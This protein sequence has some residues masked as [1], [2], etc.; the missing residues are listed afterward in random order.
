MKL[1]KLVPGLGLVCLAVLLLNTA[2][3]P[4]RSVSDIHAS[5][6]WQ[7]GVFFEQN[8]GQERN[9][10]SFVAHS[11]EYDLLLG[12]SRILFKA[13]GKEED[14]PVGLEHLAND[15]DIR[16]ETR[17]PTVVNYYVGPDP[18]NWHSGIPTFGRV[19]YQNVFSGIDL[20]FYEKDGNTEF[21]FQLAPGADPEQIRL[22]LSK[23]YAI[24]GEDLLLG[25]GSWMR[26]R[27][28]RAYQMIGGREREVAADYVIENDELRIRTGEYD[29]SRSLV[30]DPV[31]LYQGIVPNPETLSLGNGSVAS[32]SQGSAY[33][34]GIAS[35]GVRGPFYCVVTKFSSSGT[36]VY[37]T[38][39]G[40]VGL[41][42]CNAIAADGQGNAYITGPGSGF[43]ITQGV[44]EPTSGS[45]FVA[46][47]TST[48][49]LSYS[50]YVGGSDSDIAKGI[51]VDPN[52][53][54]YVTGS[55]VSNDLPLANAFQS[56]LDGS[57]DAFVSVLNPTASAFVYST[58]LG[59]GSTDQG[60]GIAVD[61]TG[62]AYVTGLTGSTDFPLKNPLLSSCVSPCDSPFLT[63]FDST[64]SALVYSTYV[65]LVGY[66]SN[67][68][69]IALDQAGN[70][71][72]G[73]GAYIASVSPSGT[74][75]FLEGL[76]VTAEPGACGVGV[77][78]AGNAY[79]G[80][81]GGL[82]ASHNPMQQSG[83]SF[84]GS[85]TNSGTLIYSTPIDGVVTGV[86]G[87]ES[88]NVYLTGTI[89]GESYVSVNMTQSPT[90]SVA[91][92]S[93]ISGQGGPALAYIPPSLAFGYQQIGVTSQP[94]ALT[95]EDLASSGTLDLSSIVVSG[96]GFA[97]GTSTCGPTLTAAGSTGAT[98]TY[99]VTFTPQ[100]A[101][102][103]TG[104]I[105][106]ADNSA[107]SPHVIPLS[108]Q[109]AVP[110]AGLNPATLSF[111]NTVVGQS[112][113]FQP[114][115]LTNTGHTTLSI[116]RLSISG[117]FSESNSCSSQVNAGQ[118]CTIDVAFT[119]TAAGNRSGTI[120]ISDNASNSPQTIPLSG[121]G[122]SE[123]LNLQTQSGS[124]S[125]ATVQAG[126]TANYSLE[127]GGAG[128]SGMATLSC[129]GAPTG[130]NCSVPSSVSV[131]GNSATPFSVSVTTTSRT[132][133]LLSPTMPSVRWLWATILPGMVLLPIA[134]CGKKLRFGKRLLPIAL[135]TFVCSC[136]GGTNSQ[137]SNPNGTPAGTYQLTV[138]AQSGSL[139]Q[140][141]QLT[142]KVQ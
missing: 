21:D 82:K 5:S 141:M 107:G 142:L 81:S 140:S 24:A 119:P 104:A 4:S 23:P 16:G 109:G 80:C 35:G 40:P 76:P 113:Q 74:L 89:T 10:V 28:P 101:N 133:G 112:S 73:A 110:A 45:A 11:R 6:R 25:S 44:V 121:T 63:K 64:G 85:F 139:S 106:I 34:L 30:I 100:D 51:A 135:L 83:N 132:M 59:G 13:R 111:P 37:Q 67:G 7:S 17:L 137:N 47:F 98:C 134:R 92:I 78:A 26:I 93:K 99:S 128:F 55:T 2:P 71:F 95:F 15:L 126:Q 12:R 14:V 77:D 29:R 136:G 43:P 124:S 87:A 117:D 65:D 122:V 69:G 36:S 50:T 94:L 39:Y 97:P 38:A 91:F 66:L 32:D 1:F 18:H 131:T 27:K 72:V 138:T 54:A 96:P 88:G 123:A 62:E 70:A 90:G 130:S 68:P 31:V 114:V 60:T 61:S 46:K 33:E 86:A 57:S 52:G 8:V 58:Y 75:N 118:D 42:T 41:G 22:R 120:T 103:A 102:L 53:N 116:S 129:K 108:G 56:A 3:V 127:I 48:G 9:D 84:L 20:L 105:T 49:Q 79:L 115:T 125:S 19:V